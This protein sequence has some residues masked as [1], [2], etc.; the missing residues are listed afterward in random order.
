MRL[1]HHLVKVIYILFII[2]ITLTD[3]AKAQISVEGGFSVGFN[4]H[5]FSVDDDSGILRPGIAL[6]GTYGFPILIKKDKWELH[7]GFYGNDLSQSFYF[8]TPS[9]ATYGERSYS[10]GISSYKFPLRIGRTI[11]WTDVTSLSPQIGFSW[12]TNRRTGQTGSGGGSYGSRVEY[13]FENRAVSKN[14]FMAE[15]GLDVNFSV[16]RN[17]ILTLGAQY[18]LG[19]QTVQEFDVTYQFNDQTYEGTVKS[20]GSGWKFNLGLKIPLYSRNR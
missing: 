2:L 8:A 12:L 16:F 17:L 15:A 7:T 6:A 1:F 19:L 9:G 10:N 4:R 14:K 20:K 3:F 11:R 18:S 5:T 13:S